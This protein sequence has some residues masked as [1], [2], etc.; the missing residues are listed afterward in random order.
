MNEAV[1]SKSTPAT[2]CTNDPAHTMAVIITV[3]ETLAELAKI[4]K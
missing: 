1:H 4:R 3:N 2:G